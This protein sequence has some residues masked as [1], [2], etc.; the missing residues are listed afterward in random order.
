MKY[1]YWLRRNAFLDN[2]VVAYYTDDAMPRAFEAHCG[3]ENGVSSRILNKSI[4]T[5][6]ARVKFKGDSST[7]RH[8]TK[9]SASCNVVPLSRCIGETGR[10][11]AQIATLIGGFIVNANCEV[12][13]A[14]LWE[15]SISMQ[16]HLRYF[17]A[18]FIVR[19]LKNF[20]LISNIY[21]L[22]SL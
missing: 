19:K 12:H 11:D 9:C 22:C 7:S 1:V 3:R 8:P 6:T 4:G 14:C 5:R 18:Y 2:M 13:F 20:S 16:M 21:F 15:W 10:R 17:M